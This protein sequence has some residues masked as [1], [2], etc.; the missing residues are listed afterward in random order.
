MEMLFVF[1]STIPLAGL[2][3]K[4]AAKNCMIDTCNLASLYCSFIPDPNSAFSQTLGWLKKTLENGPLRLHSFTRL[5]TLRWSPVQ[6]PTGSN[7]AQLLG[8]DDSRVVQQY[9][10]CECSPSL[11]LL[12][13]CSS[14]SSFSTILISAR[15]S[16]KLDF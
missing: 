3:W 1:L 10:C 4:N 6:E 11:H 16:P 13:S 14:I 2:W 12:T 8:S 9:Q 15:T 7:S 5:G